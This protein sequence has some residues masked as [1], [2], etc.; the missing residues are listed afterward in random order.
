MDGQDVWEGTATEL[1]S[2]LGCRVLGGICL[3]DQ[4]PIKGIPTVLTG[5]ENGLR[6]RLTARG[7]LD[8]RADVTFGSHGF[9]GSFQA[10][11]LGVSLGITANE[12]SRVDEARLLL[13]PQRYQLGRRF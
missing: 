9:V 13:D 1:L 6:P 7:A 5:Q 12:R 4:L 10:C 8:D 11:G 3:R 2:T